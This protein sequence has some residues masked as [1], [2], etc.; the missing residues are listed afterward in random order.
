LEASAA[1]DLSTLAL[2]RDLIPCEDPE[3]LKI[4]SRFRTREPAGADQQPHETDHIFVHDLILPMSIGA[5]EFEHRAPQR[6]RIN[7]DLS[8][9]R[10]IPRSPERHDD[11]RDIFS[12]DLIIDTIKLILG[13]G[14]MD[15]VETLAESIASAMLAHQRVAN[16]RIRIEK[17]DI[18]QACVGVEIFRERI[19]APAAITRL[20]SDSEAKIR[21][22]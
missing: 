4:E 9:R 18:L 11:M 20:F 2:M 3:S 8:I 7:V 19:A 14:H 5:Y 13:R 21:G 15:F 22:R 10:K 16:A 12:Y 6:V 17:L 1:L